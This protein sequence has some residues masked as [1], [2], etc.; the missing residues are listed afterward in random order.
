M[1]KIY[2]LLPVH[3]RCEITRRF[4]A[5]IKSQTHQNFHLILL[6]DGSTDGTVDM[7]RAEID[8]LTVIAGSGNW[9]WAGALQ[10]GYDWLKTQNAASSDLV[11]I[12]NDD[13]EFDADFLARGITLMSGQNRSLLLAPSFN[14]ETGRMIGGGMRVDWRTLQFS[15]TV[16]QLEINC[17]ST[18][19]LFV[20]IDDFL[21]L[22]GFYP[23]LLPHYLS[24]YEFTIRA[25]RR[26]MKLRVDDSLKVLVD[27]KMTGFH[28]F[29]GLSFLDFCKMYFT[30]KSDANPFAWSMFIV[31]ACPWPWKLSSLMRVWYG[32]TMKLLNALKVE[33]TRRRS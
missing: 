17:L 12:I 5:C 24:D 27:E 25:H 1:E 30:R 7:V 26:G 13:T 16:C 22:G 9:W 20:R 6:N 32:T 21:S 11:L 29:D 15:Q 4:V 33:K 31:L 14:R 23:R 3:N 18:R 10:Q 28:Q 19:G 2:I 8:K